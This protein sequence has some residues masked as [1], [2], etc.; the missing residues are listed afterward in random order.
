MK[1]KQIC[2]LLQMTVA[3]A[4]FIAIIL[5]LALGF[6]GE[7]KSQSKSLHS[8]PVAQVQSVCKRLKQNIFFKVKRAIGR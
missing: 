5:I 7:I 4:A 6:D 1:G 8:Q 3:C 2:L